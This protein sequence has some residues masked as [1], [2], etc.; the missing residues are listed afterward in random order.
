MKLIFF[1]LL[2]YTCSF[3]S[4]GQSNGPK[5]ELIWSDEFNYSGLPDSTKW[6]Y[7]IGFARN[8]EPQY[9]T[10]KRLENARVENGNLVIEALKEDYKGAHYTSASLMTLGKMHLKYGRVEVRA[11]VVKGMG[12][13]PAIWMLGI[14]RGPVKWPYCGEIDILEF[15]GKDSTQVYGTVHYADST[16]TYKFNTKKPVVGKPYNDFHVYAMNWDKDKIELYYDNLKYFEFDLKNADHAKDN[17]FKKEY[18]LLL[19]LALGR[20]GTLGGPLNDMIL[21]LK[22]QVDYVR[23]YK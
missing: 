20:D 5:R 22:Y 19:N 11:K 17:P 9:Y 16:N 18:Y 8:K 13:W 7:E 21:P 10:R 14:N 1:L 6:N 3:S 23:I 4:F 2:L 15:V 12:A